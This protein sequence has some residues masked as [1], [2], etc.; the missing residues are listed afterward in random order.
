MPPVP[1]RQAAADVLLWIDSDTRFL[2]RRGQDVPALPEPTRSLLE[3]AARGE[4]VDPQQLSQ[5]LTAAG[6][7]RHK[8][9]QAY[10]RLS[11]ADPSAPD[12]GDPPSGGLPSS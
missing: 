6:V 8:L 7:L 1:P 9:S 12:D 10:L 5:A 4:A 2:L 3:A 11:A